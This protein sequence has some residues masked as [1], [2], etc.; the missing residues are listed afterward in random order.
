MGYYTRLH[1]DVRLKRETPK[2][3][4]RVIDAEICQRPWNSILPAVD[5]KINHP[6]FNCYRWPAMFTCINFNESLGSTFRKHK[7][8]GY[9]LLKIDTEFKNYDDEIEL[10]VDWISPWIIGR[11]KKQYIGWYQ[12]EGDDHRTN[13]YVETA[14]FSK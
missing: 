9:W 6:F 7:A 8:H 11:K 1:I 4:L 5:P 2:E 13:I 3:F 12:G 10:F 14:K